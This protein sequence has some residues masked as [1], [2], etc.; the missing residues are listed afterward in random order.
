M[1]PRPP[2]PDDDELVPPEDQ[3]APLGGEPVS[4]ED[5]EPEEA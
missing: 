4:I 2:K 3:L 5:D 1:T